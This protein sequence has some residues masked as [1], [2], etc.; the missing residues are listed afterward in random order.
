MAM[1]G[2]IYKLTEHRN[3]KNGMQQ[4]AH[5][6]LEWLAS[7]LDRSWKIPCI[8][9]VIIGKCVLGGLEMAVCLRIPSSLVAVRAS[10]DLGSCCAFQLELC[11]ESKPYTTINTHTGLYI[12]IANR[13]PF[14]ISAAP[15]IFQRILETLLHGIPNFCVYLDDILVT[16][17]TTKEHLDNLK[18]VPTRLETAG[19]RLKQQKCEFLMSEVEYLGHH[20]SPDG[21]QPTAT[22][23]K[24]ITEAP[25]PRS[26]SELKLF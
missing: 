7:S 11:D 21:L 20:I 12:H 3:P 24:A 15:A 8:M 25:A 22:K 5:I 6:V 2:G 13:L 18:E 4:A 16:G 26:V 9:S 23:V 1:L 17:K 10:A 19:M 14:D